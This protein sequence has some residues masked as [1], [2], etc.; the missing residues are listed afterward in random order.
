[1][2]VCLLASPEKT[3]DLHLWP[4]VFIAEKYYNHSWHGKRI[5]PL[6]ISMSL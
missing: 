2:I 4:I 6:A 1:M 5:M 3:T